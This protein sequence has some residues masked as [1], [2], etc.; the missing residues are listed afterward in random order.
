MAKKKGKQG[1]RAA[2]PVAGAA[3]AGGAERADERGARKPANVAAQVRSSRKRKQQRVNVAI[4]AGIATVIVAAIAMQVIREVSRPGERH[5]SQG[6]AHLLSINS[7]HVPYNTDPPTSG[8]HMPT[9]AA[10]GTYLEPIAD[11]YLVHNMEDAGVV[12]WYDM[13]TPE[14][15][16]ERAAALEAV[17]RGF[18]NV[19]VVPRQDLGS[20]YVL[21]AWTRLQ[22]FDEIDEEGM[23]RFIDAYEGIDHHPR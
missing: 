14:E 3:A 13:G 5:P 23:R 16:A 15:N 6:N 10:W 2:K 17:A 22:R 21:T 7:P 20:P 1:A 12:L 19:I 9:I 4:G 11:E 8:P 18:R